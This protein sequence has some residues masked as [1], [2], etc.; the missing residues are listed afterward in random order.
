MSN[1]LNSLV[2]RLTVGGRTFAVKSTSGR[3][4]YRDITDSKT[5]KFITEKQAKM[6]DA[7]R[8]RIVK[9]VESMKLPTEK[10]SLKAPATPSKKLKPAKVKP[11]KVADPA[12]KKAIAKAAAPLKRAK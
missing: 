2:L 1:A 3:V 6:L 7:L 12:A 5:G 9:N 8:E 10:A 11:Q 4:S